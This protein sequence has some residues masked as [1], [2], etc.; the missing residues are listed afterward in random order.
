MDIVNP[1]DGIKC[2]FYGSLTPRN[3]CYVLELWLLTGVP[4]K[5]HKIQAIF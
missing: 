2:R 4:I 3:Y 1:R 5:H